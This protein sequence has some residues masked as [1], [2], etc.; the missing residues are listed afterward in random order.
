MTKHEFDA[1]VRAQEDEIDQRL[2][3]SRYCE[4]SC[5]HVSESW[6]MGMLTRGVKKLMRPRAHSTSGARR[7]VRDTELDLDTLCLGSV[8]ERGGGFPSLGG[9]SR[10]DNGPCTHGGRA[11]ETP[12]QR[13]SAVRGIPPSPSGPIAPRRR[14]DSVTEP[15][16]G[17]ASPRPRQ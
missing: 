11:G 5:H 7:V 2:D 17:P 1:I 4:L 16:N 6:V 13:A 3:N 12:H 8:Q 14:S 10:D 15:A 9:F